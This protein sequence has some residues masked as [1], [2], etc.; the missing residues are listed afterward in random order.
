MAAALLDFPDTGALI[1]AMERD[2]APRPTS[3]RLVGQ[4]RE[5]LWAR[6]ACEMFV[7]RR[8]NIGSSTQ[9]GDQIE[10]LV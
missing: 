2:E 8:H 5:L 4:K 3:S 1:R 6:E 9:A 7:A 10:D